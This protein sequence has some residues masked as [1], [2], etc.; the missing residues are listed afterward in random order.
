VLD[1]AGRCC[2]SYGHNHIHLEP[3]QLRREVSQPIVSA[4]GV[5]VFDDEVLALN[6]AELAQPLQ[7]CITLT[8]VSRQRPTREYTY[9]GDFWWRLR[10][11]SERCREQT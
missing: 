7:E 4:L 9:P 10:L 6:I 2:A 3:D 1:G 11:G 5:S 8:R